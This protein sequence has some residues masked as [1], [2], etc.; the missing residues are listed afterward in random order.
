MWELVNFKEIM[1]KTPHCPVATKKICLTYIITMARIR[2]MHSL[3]GSRNFTLPMHK[4]QFMF[5]SA[6]D[7][8]MG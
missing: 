3:I 6:K 7:E 4:Q 8:K 5:F 1:A 2:N